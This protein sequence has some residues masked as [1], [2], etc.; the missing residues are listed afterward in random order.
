[1][2]LL[3]SCTIDGEA[4]PPWVNLHMQSF[5]HTKITSDREQNLSYSVNQILISAILNLYRPGKGEHIYPCLL[6]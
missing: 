1:M 5:S 2:D 3:P 6:V 4:K